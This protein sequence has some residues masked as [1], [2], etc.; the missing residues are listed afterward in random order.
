MIVAPAAYH[1]SM[2]RTGRNRSH[3][4]ILVSLT[5]VQAQATMQGSTQDKQSPESSLPRLLSS[6][7]YTQ[8]YASWEPNRFRVDGTPVLQPAVAEAEKYQ[9]LYQGLVFDALSDDSGN[10]ADAPTLTLEWDKLNT[11]YGLTFKFDT[12]LGSIVSEMHLEVFRKGASI[13]THDITN[14]QKEVLEEVVAFTNFDKLVITFR[15]TLQPKRRVRLTYLLMG[16]G[17]EFTNN[18]VV[19]STLTREADLLSAVLPSSAFSFEV[20]N[21]EGTYDLD[22]PSNAANFFQAR[23]PV[24]VMYGY[25]IEN[26]KEPY[27]IFG[28][29]YMMSGRP[30]VDDTSLRAQA[31]N[32]LDSMDGEFYK[33]K[34]YP[35]GI[36]LYELAKQVFEDAK[37]FL[38][39]GVTLTYYIDSF[40]KQV[41]TKAPLPVADHKQCLQYIANAGMCTVSLGRDGSVVLQSAFIPDKSVADNNHEDYATSAWLLESPKPSVMYVTWEPDVFTFQ[42]G[43]RLVPAPGDES[44]SGYC[45]Y[46]SSTIAGADGSLLKDGAY[47]EITITFDANFSAYNLTIFFDAL[48]NMFANEIEVIKYTDGVESETWVERPAAPTHRMSRPVINFNKLVLR[49]KSMNRPNVRLRIGAMSLGAETDYVLLRENTAG[50]PKSV[51]LADVATLAVSVPTITESTEEEQLFSEEFIVSGTQ[52]IHVSYGDA[53]FSQ[54]ATIVGE[55]QI[56]E[57]THYSYA[58]DIKVSTTSEHKL[59]LTVMGKKLL[60]NSSSVLTQSVNSTGS[61]EPLENPLITDT[62]LAKEYLKWSYNYV[63]DNKQFEIPFRGDPVIDPLDLIYYE[64]RQKNKI[65]ARVAKVTLNAGQ[66]ISGNITLKEVTNSGKFSKPKDRL[67]LKKF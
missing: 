16:I 56:L 31:T 7:T 1:E 46:V 30:E 19:S 28:G 22:D 54:V 26:G 40:L 15:K 5:D 41:K 17:L 4:R 49:F 20:S 60:L 3:I 66:G 64:T 2:N 21:I 44:L 51:L 27:W 47:P 18:E 14:N 39:P 33:G 50:N 43:T 57:Q 65:L 58:S 25:E 10:F 67:G 24:S 11:V 29:Q 52:I 9:Y 61:Y 53:V 38:P 36:T 8:A 59:T 42:E 12:L 23:Q 13:A 32:I 37:Q 45:G 48:H 62:E 63:V 35:E 55:G 6:A 34:Y